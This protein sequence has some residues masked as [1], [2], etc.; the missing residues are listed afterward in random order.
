MLNFFNNWIKTDK[1]P[2]KN[3]LLRSFTVL[4]SFIP[5]NQFFSGKIESV[6]YNTPLAITG[7]IRKAI[8]GIRFV[9][10]QK[11]NN[12]V[13]TYVMFLQTNQ[14][15]KAVISFQSDTSKT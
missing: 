6:Q 12:M 5:E 10:S 11:Q 9:T 8:P 4:I 1:G 13:K 14:N 15:S 3:H 7:A 2:S